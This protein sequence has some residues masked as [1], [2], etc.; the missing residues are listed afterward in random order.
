MEINHS[1]Q[2]STAEEEEQRKVNFLQTLQTIAKHNEL[3]NSGLESY[4]MGVNQ[5]ADLTDAEYKSM[6]SM[7]DPT[8]QKPALAEPYIADPESLSSVPK[9]FDWR[10]SGKVTPVRNQGSCGSCWAFS[11]IAAIES[12]YAIKKN[13]PGINLSEEQLVD[14]MNSKCGGQLITKGFDYVKAH[15]VENEG[16]YPYKAGSGHYGKCTEKASAPHTHIK[17]YKGLGH[18]SGPNLATD[19]Q[20]MAAI[21]ANGPLSMQFNAAGNDFRNY[22][23]GVITSN[24]MS[25][26]AAHA[27]L[28][29]GW[30]TEGGHDYWLF[31]NSWGT[32]WGA[33]GYFKM[34]RGHNLR[35]INEFLYIPTL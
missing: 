29:I 11:V 19:G 25:W 3:F 21:Q 35:H 24:D 30:G 33:K 26:S 34:A 28:L 2:Y 8:V 6:F 15:G 13:K 17:G 1:K 32:A 27:V 4:E 10:Q 14:C 16:Q 22:K 5:F 9:S 7:P 23:S 12:A 18:A 20:I 31:K